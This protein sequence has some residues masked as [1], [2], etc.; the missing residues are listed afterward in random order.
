MSDLAPPELLIYD[1]NWTTNPE[2]TLQTSMGTLVVELYPNAAPITVANFLSYVEIDFYDGLLFHRVMQDFMI[3]GGGFKTGM[4]YQVSPYPSIP[5]ESNNGLSNLRGTIAMARTADPHSATSQFYINHVDNTFLD[6]SSVSYGYAVF[7]EV[8]TGLEVVDAIAAVEV[9]TRSLHEDVPVTDVSIQSAEQSVTGT[10]YSNTG[11]IYIGGLQQDM[12]W[13]YSIDDGVSWQEGGA[14]GYFTLAEGAYAMD[15]VQV[16]QRDTAD[17]VSAPISPP[18]VIFVDQTSPTVVISSSDSV[19]PSGDGGVIITFSF[20]EDPG[21]SFQWDGSSGDIL[22]TGGTV[23]PLSGTGLI[24]SATLVA[25]E[26]SIEATVAVASDTFS[27]L[28]GNANIDGEDL[29]NT[30]KLPVESSAS[31]DLQSV[32]ISCSSGGRQLEGVEL[33]EGLVTDSNGGAT[34]ELATAPVTLSPTLEIDSSAE[35][36]VDLQDSI[37]ILKQIVGLDSFNN[38]QMVAADFDRNGSVGLNDAID[39]LKHVVGLPGSTPQWMFMEAG[40]DAPLSDGVFEV[41]QN[42]SDIELVGVLLGDVDGSWGGG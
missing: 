9:E 33:M 13:E 38:Y 1:A 6:F 35:K 3:Q 15:S 17:H 22:V 11:K 39:I 34:V 20:S 28:A 16:R 10:A 7:G 5:L 42:S 25:D 36:A 32:G 8:V 14:E 12:G 21:D 4:E 30:L 24:R 19:L 37:L 18:A 2:V 40:N 29:D 26:S 27:D 23:S 41:D 31:G